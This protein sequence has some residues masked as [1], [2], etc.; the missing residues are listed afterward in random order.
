MAQG[1]L[2]CAPEA[3]FWYWVNERH[4]IYCRRAEGKPK[5]WTDDPILRDYKFTNVFRQLDR[6]TVWLT[7]HF[8]RPHWDDDPALLFFNIA[9]YRMFNWTGTGERLGWQTSW[10]LA[11]VRRLLGAALASGEQV[12]TGA[13][14]I[15]SAFGRPKIDSIV[16]VCAEL[17]KR[18]QQITVTAQHTGSLEETSRRL[19][20]VD[21][22]GGFMA[23]EILTD[24]R[25]TPLLNQAHDIHTWAH[26]GPG[27]LRG[28]QRLS[29]GLQRQD[30]LS[31]LLG[32]VARSREPGVLGTHVPPLEPRDCEHAACEWDKMCRIK[33]GEGRP[34]SKYNGRADA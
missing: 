26:V 12:F 17:W 19:I 1:S 34:R 7:E 3:L 6:G 16:D 4:A 9:W 23:Y 14:I 8:I 21:Y 30:A 20:E 24:M 29:P 2:T 28:L 33:F 31:K 10:E 13:H 25:H 18:R 32:L 27:A 15:R 11:R 22:V 5:P